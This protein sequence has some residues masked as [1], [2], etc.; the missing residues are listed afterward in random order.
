MNVEK[1]C[2]MLEKFS[3]RTLYYMVNTL[4]NRILAKHLCKIQNHSANIKTEIYQS[5]NP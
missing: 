1:P 3:L 2:C 5:T 4:H